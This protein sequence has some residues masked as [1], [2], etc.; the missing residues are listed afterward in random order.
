MPVDKD[1]YT[2]SKEDIEKL[3]NGESVAKWSDEKEYEIKIL[4]INKK[5]KLEGMLIANQFVKC[6]SNVLLS[7]Y[8]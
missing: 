3:N 7:I 1:K 2:F 8:Y 4:D 5:E 6:E